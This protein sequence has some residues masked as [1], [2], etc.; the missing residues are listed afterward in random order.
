MKCSCGYITVNAKSFSNHKRYGCKSKPILRNCLECGCL[1]PT[2][3]KPADGR[4]FCNHK[5]YALWR[6]KNLLGERSTNYKDGKCKE[7]QLLRARLK[8]RVWRNKIF[9]RD[10]YKCS[11]CFAKFSRGGLVCHHIVKK[12]T[13]GSDSSRNLI[14]MCKRCHPDDKPI[15][16]DDEE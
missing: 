6:S 1:L 10:N 5:C 3:I 13:G 4:K 11:V 9:K 15:M 2:K 12:E 8:S 16:S 14:T 7:R